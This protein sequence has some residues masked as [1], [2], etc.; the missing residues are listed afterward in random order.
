MRQAPES[1]PA[2]RRRLRGHL[3]DAAVPDRACADAELVLGELVANAVQHGLPDA[4]GL[5]EVSWCLHEDRVLLSVHDSG[6]VE[7]LVAGDLR[8]W[9]DTGRG[10]ALVEH[11]CERWGHDGTDG[12]RVDAELVFA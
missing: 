9:E 6:H 12:T 8:S 3:R 10:L 2:A 5:I 4:K 1:A 11:L 7:Q